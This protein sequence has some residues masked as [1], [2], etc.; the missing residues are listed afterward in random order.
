MK[1][2]IIETDHSIP[3]AC[4][5]LIN[6]DG[7]TILY[8]GD[9]RF[10]GSSGFT[11][12]QFIT[13][14]GVPVDVLIIEGTRVDQKCIITEQDVQSRL[15]TE[16]RGVDGLVL[17]DFNWKDIQRFATIRKVANSLGRTLLI[18]PNLAFL[19]HEL[20]LA[21]P[22]KHEDP[23]KMAGVAV[24]MKRQAS[25]LYSKSDYKTTDAGYLDEW[26]SAQ[27]KVNDNLKKIKDKME[28]QQPITADESKAWDWATHHLVHGVRAYQVRAAP[29]K[30]A[31]MCSFWD[32]NELFDLSDASCD[33]GTA[34]YIKAACEPFN[35]EMMTDERKLMHWLDHFHV[36]YEKESAPGG[37]GMFVKRNHASGHASRPELAELIAKVNPRAFVFP[38][39]TAYPSEFKA[40]VPPGPVVIADIERGREYAV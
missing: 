12:D 5:F 23:M 32:L 33:M 31:L 19:L 21:H 28:G 2:R 35:D 16:M 37:N 29:R 34:R 36:A 9:I 22:L 13:K 4:A 40:L 30:F 3:G 7:K 15:V 26:G 39:H 8:T 10:H 27:A 1:V 24:Y 20:H 25:F 38:V 11:V 14:I 6:V 18:D 17:V